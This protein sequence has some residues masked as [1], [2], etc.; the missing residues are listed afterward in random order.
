MTLAHCYYD[1][2]TDS[3]CNGAKECTMWGGIYD[4]TTKECDW[5]GGQDG[6]KKFDACPDLKKYSDG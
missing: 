3:R 4:T 5:S 2:M 1:F 6:A